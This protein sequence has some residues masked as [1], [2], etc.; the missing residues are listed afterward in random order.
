MKDENDSDE[1]DGE[2]SKVTEDEEMKDGSV[3]ATDEFNFD[4]YDE[5]RKCKWQIKRCINQLIWIC[6]SYF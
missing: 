4:K 6:I 1:E 3:N 2:A 5:E